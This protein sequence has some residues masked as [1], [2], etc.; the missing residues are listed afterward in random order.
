MSKKTLVALLTIVLVATAGVALV[1]AQSGTDTV[2]HNTSWTFQNL[3]DDTANVQVDF[4]DDTGVQVA[5]EAITVEK[6]AA[7]WAPDQPYL[8]TSLNGS[9]VASSDQPLAA[10]VNQVAQNTT[11]G[12][13]GNATYIGFNSDSVAPSMYAPS[14]M[15]GLAGIYWTELSIQSTA[16]SGDITVNVHYFNEDGTEV[17]GSPSSYVVPAG[18]PVRVAQED[19][20]Y[21][22]TNWI[23][24]VRVDAQDGTTDIALVVNE[25]YGGNRRKFNQFYSYEGFASGAETVVVPNVFINGYDGLYNASATVQN[26]GSV[27]AQVTWHFY[28]NTPGNPSMG[29]EIH[30][31]SNVITTSLAVYFPDAAYAQTLMDGYAAGD[32]EWIGTVIFECTNGQP[33]VAIVN[34]LSGSFHAASFTGL[35]EGGTKLNYP[36]A[37]VDGFGGYAQTSFAIV[38]M[39]DTAGA[40]NVT[41]NYIPDTDPDTGCPGCLPWSDTY[42]FTINDNKYQPTHLPASVLSNGEYIGAIEI[43]V[44]TPGKTIAGVMNEILGFGA[45]N[46]DNFTSFN[47]TVTP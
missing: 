38:D 45:F 31:F 2:T 46:M 7:F 43:V 11:S 19:E 42:D 21:L 14:V 20:S 4:Y 12:K 22:P 35:S 41:V 9:I 10:T 3:G 27:P 5:S 15:N 6:S 40:V 44:N 13:S 1:Y 24:S 39:S 18:S 33:L 8:P 17:T 25:F 47:G 32:D 30:S 29:T 16:P 34:E 36:M 26:L 23:G 28:D 37:F